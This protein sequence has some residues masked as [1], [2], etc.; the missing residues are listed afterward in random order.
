MNEEEKQ[1]PDE[2]PAMA[3]G[4]WA[5]ETNAQSEK[6]KKP[7]FWEQC[8]ALMHDLVYILSIITLFFVF[9]VRI[10]VVDGFSMY[11]TLVNGDR[12]ALLSNVFY[13]DG[14]IQNGDVVVALVPTFASAEPI[15]KRV[16]ATEGQTVDIDFDLGIVYVDGVALDEPYIYEPTWT[17]FYGNGVAFPMTIE[18]GHVFLMGDNRNDS[19]DSRRLDI[20]QVD[21]RHI[22]GKVLL[23][24]LPGLDDRYT[25]ARDWGR[26]GMVN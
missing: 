12:V 16:I 9:A 1:I 15:V 11:P 10:V 20:G 18:D 6:P 3:A 2:S 4:D 5:Q 26:I 19:S 22:L 21:T 25:G 13:H 7:S 23:V 14:S 8:Y 17:Q 24:M